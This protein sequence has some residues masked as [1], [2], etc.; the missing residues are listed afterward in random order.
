MRRVFETIC[1][2]IVVAVFCMAGYIATIEF[3]DL[4][5]RVERIEQKL[6]EPIELEII[7]PD[8]T[9]PFGEP[10]PAPPLVPIPDENVTFTGRTT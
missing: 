5:Q 9:I 7:I 10:T 4:R 1:I 6:E 8:I 3:L 2:T